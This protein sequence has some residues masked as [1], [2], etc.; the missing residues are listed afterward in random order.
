MVETPKDYVDPEEETFEQWVNRGY[1]E[2]KPWEK[3]I[4]QA[5][6]NLPITILICV[7]IGYL[8]GASL[9]KFW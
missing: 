4:Y 1:D 3:A 9:G 8:V 2:L 5:Q 7:F 6:S